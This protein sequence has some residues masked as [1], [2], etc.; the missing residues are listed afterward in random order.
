MQV[1]REGIACDYC[2]TKYVHDFVY[3]S[4]DF[5]QAQSNANIRPPIAQVLQTQIVSSF[6]ICE[7]CFATISQSVVN[8]YKKNMSA[9]RKPQVIQ[10]CELS[11]QAMSGTYIY[12]HCNVVKANV[13]IDGQP[14]VCVKCSQ[15]VVDKEKPCQCGGDKFVRVAS[16][17]TDD[18]HLEIIM[19]E[20]EYIKFRQNAERF[21]Q[22]AGEWSTQS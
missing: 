17:A 16:V 21:K 19:S 3:Y 15:P 12:Y 2:G 20:S 1:G 7:S 14:Y 9:K 13:R 8:N 10:F 18:R 22:I 5:R 6:D 11:G 4:F